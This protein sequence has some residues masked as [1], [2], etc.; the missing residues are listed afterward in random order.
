MEMSAVHGTVI[1]AQSD[2]YQEVMLTSV[3]L[4]MNLAVRK[5]RRDLPLLHEIKA[6]CDSTRGTI[7]VCADL[8]RVAM[9]RMLWPQFARSIRS[10]IGNVELLAT[11]D[12]LIRVDHRVRSWAMKHGA[13]DVIPRLSHVRV[14]SSV[15]PLM[16]PMSQIFGIEPDA[17]RVSEYVSGLHGNLRD[18]ADKFSTYQH[19]WRKLEGVGHI[20][21]LI[22]ESMMD[23]GSV[24][25][26]D[27]RYRL[28]TYP[29]CFLGREATTWL[30]SNLSISR[31]QAVDVGE[32]LRV[33]GFVYHV[34]MDQPFADSD[35]YYRYRR[36]TGVL[37][38]I[39]P[40]MV[41]EEGLSIRGFDIKDRTWRGISFPRCFVGAEA[42]KWMSSFYGISMEDA[43]SLGQLM[44]DI[45]L[46]RHVTDEHGFVD[47]PFF[48]RMTLDS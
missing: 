42:V 24:Q 40:D 32:L 2:H 44:L 23:S 33:L 15:R 26:M 22:A 17:Q 5:I 4:S 29:N 21:D 16:E 14:K 45:Y 3:F 31:A 35:F 30:S 25:A 7:V 41:M 19:T 12:N 1:L 13:H 18:E 47:Q 39:D 9:E 43:I 34:A 37:T 28:K 36:E 6:V 46:F 11:H 20:P 38:K 10:L 27:R 8:G 48:Y